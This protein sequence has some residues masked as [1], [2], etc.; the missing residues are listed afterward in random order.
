ML[1]VDMT[2]TISVIVALAAIVSPVIT[3]L[4]NNAHDSKIHKI[5]LKQH[6]KENTVLYKRKIFEDYV[7]AAGTLAELPNTPNAVSY[8]GAYLPALMYAPCELQTKMVE[9]NDLLVQREYH[10]AI[11]PL[12]DITR[13]ISEL[14]RES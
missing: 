4:I 14:L 5:D 12:E 11:G 2:I 7:R 8:G 1:N 9:V 10:A 6:E 13:Q 3:A